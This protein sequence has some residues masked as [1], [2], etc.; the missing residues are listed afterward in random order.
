MEKVPQ[1]EEM[2]QLRTRAVHGDAPLQRLA[3][4]ERRPL[5][6]GRLARPARS[7]LAHWSLMRGSIHA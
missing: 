1:V 6:A 3:Q 4:L 5:R 2:P 7:F